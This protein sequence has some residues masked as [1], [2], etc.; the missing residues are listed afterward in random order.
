M[1]VWCFLVKLFLIETVSLLSLLLAIIWQ[2]NIKYKNKENCICFG[3]YLK[4]NIKKTNLVWPGSTF[5]CEARPHSVR[6]G[7]ILWDQASMCEESCEEGLFLWG[8]TSFCEAR[9]HSGCPDLVL[10]GLTS[11]WEVRPHYVRLD[12][13]MWVK[14]SFMEAK[15]HSKRQGLIL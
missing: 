10:G 3:C 9:N 7:L 2:P 14:N 5:F 8:Y 15:P 1:I 13:N 12:L 11:F 6:P 4:M